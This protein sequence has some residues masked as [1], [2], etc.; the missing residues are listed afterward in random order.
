MG[1]KFKYLLLIL[2][3]SDLA[4]LVGFGQPD[5]PINADLKSNSESWKVK[6]KQNGIWGKKPALVN[7]GPV[8]TFSTGAEKNEQS[9]REVNRELF[10]KNVHTIKSTESSMELELNGADTA[11]VIMLTVREETTKEKNVAGTLAG[12]NGSE[13][14]YYRVNN[15]LDEMNLSFQNDSAVWH[16]I[17]MD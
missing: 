4:P 3:L 14:E 9:S 13:E 5:I 7:F 17:K 16:Y 8:K 12:G 15:W 11:I 6:V 2:C 10:W 1:R